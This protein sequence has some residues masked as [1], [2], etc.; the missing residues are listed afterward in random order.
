MARGVPPPGTWQ[1]GREP[2]RQGARCNC[3]LPKCNCTLLVRTRPG[4][5]FWLL[6][7]RAPPPGGKVQLHLA[8]VQL[9]LA[10]VQLHLARSHSAGARFWLLESRVPPP[11]G[12]VHVHLGR[13]HSA[14]ARV[15][16]LGGVERGRRGSGWEEG[17]GGEE[18]PKGWRHGGSGGNAGR[19]PL[20][21]KPFWYW[22][23]LSK[24]RRHPRR[25]RRHW[26]R[27]QSWSRLERCR[28]CLF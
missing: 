12:N 8:K 16:A 22:S 19:G 9:H 27:R 15:L 2:P 18:S 3:T 17:C 20:T 14:G 7:S 5:V 10:K 13:S 4:R 25:P 21:I 6:E 24:L 23:K 28:H 26:R 1:R 11:G